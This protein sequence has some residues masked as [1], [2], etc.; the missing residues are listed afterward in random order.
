MDQGT[1]SKFLG[2]SLKL[3]LRCC[4]FVQ[5]DE[6]CFYPS[7]RKEAQC[8]SRSAW[9]SCSAAAFLAAISSRD[10]HALS[11]T[12]ANGMRN[13]ALLPRAVSGVVVRLVVML[14]LVIGS[15]LVFLRERRR[16]PADL[17]SSWTKEIGYAHTS[18]ARRI[19]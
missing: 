1:Y 13:K 8:F 6:V 2:K 18:M 10:A 5:I 16:A 14:I 7:F 4:S 19:S 9:A 15:F 12:H 11:S 3:S 17:G